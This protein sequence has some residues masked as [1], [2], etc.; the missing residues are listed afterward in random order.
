[1]TINTLLVLKKYKA[2]RYAF[3]TSDEMRARLE[4]DSGLDGKAS[5][6]AIKSYILRREILS[7]SP[8]GE[9]DLVVRYKGQDASIEIKTGCCKTLDS[10][11]A[12]LVIYAPELDLTQPLEW[13]A[14]IF[15]KAEWHKFLNGYT[16]RGQLLKNDYDRHIQSFRSEGRPNASAPIREYIDTVCFD[17]PILEDELDNFEVVEA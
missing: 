17:Q 14:Y 5:E 4:R 2:M 12:D 13:Q 8:A 7:V 11:N 6:C 3:A 1:M 16:G 15:T 9:P 10:M